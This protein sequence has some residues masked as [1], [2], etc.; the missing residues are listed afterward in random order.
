MDE[1][2][3]DIVGMSCAA[4]SARIEKAVSKVSGVSYCSVNLLTNT[5]VTKGSASS[6]KIITAVKNAGYSAK[7]NGIKNNEEKIKDSE[8]NVLKKRLFISLGLLL[9][10]MYMSM[11][12]MMLKWPVPTVFENY[13]CMVFLEFLITSVILIIN[14]KFFINGFKA[15]MHFAPN[16]D[17][18]VALGSGIS[19]IYSL[20]IL[21]LLIYLQNQP[22]VIDVYFESSSTIV[23]LITLGKLLEAISKGKTKSALDKLISLSPKTGIIVKDD[24]EVEVSVEEIKPNDIFIL[25][26][27]YYVPVDGIVIDGFSTLDESSITGE[28]IP[29]EKKEGDNVNASSINCN[30]YLKC[31]ATKTGSDTLFSKIIKMVEDA[32]VSKPK[33][34]RIADKISFYFVP[35]I[36]LLSI[37]TMLVYFFLDYTVSYA[38]ERAI[39]VLI[40]SCPCALGLATPLAVMVGTGLGARN[41]I[42]FKNAQSI[43]TAGKIKTI[44]LD[45]TGTITIGKPSVTDIIPLGGYS[46]NDLLFY[47]SSLEKKSEHP[48]SYAI[49]AFYGDKT[50]SDLSDFKV[51]LGNGLSG[52]MMKDKSILRGGSLKYIESV[53]HVDE[54]TSSLVSRLSDEGKTPLVFSKNNDIVGIIGIRDELKTDAGSS[55][56]ELKKM[57]IRVVM[58]TGD[59]EKTANAIAKSANIDEVF[60]SVL[61]DGKTE[62]VKKL[63][64]K[65]VTAMVGDGINDSPALMAANVGISVSSGS[66]IAVDSSDI[67]LMK[68]T[69]DIL[70][71]SIKLSKYTIKNIYENLFWAFIY[72]I[73][74]IPMAMGLF[75]FTLKPMYG[76]L[77]MSLSSFCVCMNALRLNLVHIFNNKDY[78]RPKEFIVNKKIKIEGMSCAHCEKRVREALLTIK[79]L[80]NA[81]VSYKTG[82]AH[83]TVNENVTDLQLKNAIEGQ[84]YKVI[85]II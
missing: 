6:D 15:L 10:L 78:N 32:S 7:E 69:L 36:L 12:H 67:V 71:A 24:K 59:N 70:P 44:A 4:C 75:G 38:L 55:V 48:I 46:K 62:I 74:C 68:N 60:S 9:V 33:I 31:I 26:P 42:L 79:G 19:Y 25:K 29:V 77:A 52:I 1:K 40:I 41:G 34:S 53:L 30:G 80:S 35:C 56:L 58:L 18:L 81:E 8:I 65:N 5:M 57:G 72:N 11:G 20:Y 16:M 13:V 76:A 54:E 63:S 23:T 73:I 39:T 51:H 22:F 43:E 84:D 61:P 27:G 66:D 2:K 17:T 28:S 83:V 82:E 3:F 21:F 37:I 49:L 50:V 47:A 45:K 14:R 64:E 85:E